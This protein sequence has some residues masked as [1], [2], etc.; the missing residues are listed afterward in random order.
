[1]V[2]ALV[3]YC[4]IGLMSDLYFLLVGRVIEGDEQGKRKDARRAYQM[5]SKQGSDEVRLS[6]QRREDE[7]LRSSR[8]GIPLGSVRSRRR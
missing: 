7:D 5:Q 2:F 6:R 8:L 4:V 1:V 3:C